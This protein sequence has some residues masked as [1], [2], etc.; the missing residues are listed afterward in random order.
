MW[1]YSFVLPDFIILYVFAIYYF[2]QPRI[3]IKLNRSFLKL[4]IA[5]CAVILSDTV[6]SLALENAGFFSTFTLRSLNSV[7]FMLFMLRSFYFFVFTE[8][9]FG[10]RY[11]RTSPIYIS[12]YIVFFV[13]EL[14]AIANFFFDTIFSISEEGVYSRAAF[15]NVIYFSSFLFLFLSFFSIALYRKKLSL[16]SNLSLV[17]FNLVLLIGYI[18]RICFPKYIIMNLFSLTAIII[19]FLAFENPVLYLAIKVNA[20]NKKALY[21]VFDEID[22]KKL[23]LVLG[24]TI[25]NYNEIREIYGSLQTDKGISLIIQYIIKT[26]PD[27]MRFYLHDGRFVLMGK[28]TCSSE[29]LMNEIAERFKKSWCTGKDVDIYLEP[30][31]VQLD[32]EISFANPEKLLNAIFAA[33][34]KAESMDES[35]IIINSDTLESIEDNTRIK[36][37]M[38]KAVEN[39]AVE[40]FLQPLMDSRNFKLVGAEALARI[41]DEEGN[42]IPPIKFIPLAEKNGRINALGEQMFE[43]ACKFIH[44]NDIKRMG[45]SW[46]NVNLSPV[47][48]LRSD[49]NRHFLKIIQ[50]YDVSPELIHLEITEESMIDYTLLQKQIQTMRNS[51][52]QFVLDDYGSGYSNVSRLKRCPFINIKLDMD[53]VRD[54]EKSRDNLL[55]MLVETF[56]QMR[57][58]VTAEGIETREM[59]DSLT[60]IGCDYLQGYYF[61]KPLPAEEFAKTYGN[62]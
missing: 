1:N 49:L 7:Y 6:A 28:S 60:R 30:K 36:R 15:Y 17:A 42:L 35:N 52:F 56:K 9:V 39:N 33:L 5:D 31:F 45:L 61:S 12:T 43:K 24:F 62:I 32:S 50:K 58:T 47:Q 21:A 41:R 25:K 54:Y 55:P 3:P 48:F 27:L 51:G 19:I 44:D 8:N 57:F 29:N 46:I 34:K 11:R 16:Y 37:C 23:P 2:A 53:L 59:V 18:S 20:F 22:E 14:F 38:E 26:Y 40:M 10:L 4:M 13:F